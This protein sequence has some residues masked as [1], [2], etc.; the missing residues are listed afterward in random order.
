M[1]DMDHRSSSPAVRVF[2][3]RSE[4]GMVAAQEI[5]S[6][7]RA[8]IAENGRARVAFAAAPSQ[9]ETL[10]YLAEAGDIDWSLV[11]AFHLD[12]YVGLAKDAPERFANWLRRHL[13]DRL[14]FRSVQII[15]P[16][17]D[18]AE[19]EARRYAAVIAEAPLDVVVLGIGV[20]AHIAFNDPPVAD[21]DDP[22]FAKVVDLDESCRQQQVDDECFVR[23]DDVPGSAVTLTIPALMAGRRLF[24]VVPGA[25]K[26]NAVRATL[27][28]PVTTGWPST[29]LRTHPDCR[30][31]L[32]PAS[33]E[34]L[35]EIS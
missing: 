15:D 12:E 5:A 9:S 13:F 10:A 24:C 16:D 26:A 29:V 1:I 4:L 17:P 11:D 34:L 30:L 23:L 14:P 28:E 21:F 2:S 19:N 31:Y 27:E 7:I 18:D 32:D 25:L 22:V 8:T 20:N 35:A 33:A 3:S 6:A